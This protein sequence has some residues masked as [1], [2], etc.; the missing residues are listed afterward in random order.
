VGKQELHARAARLSAHLHGT[1]G[2]DRGLVRELT[3]DPEA[4]GR[5]DPT[6]HV[7]VRRVVDRERDPIGP[8]F[9][10]RQLHVR[11]VA[12]QQV[13]D[14]HVADLRVELQEPDAVVQDRRKAAVSGRTVTA[15]FTSIMSTGNCSAAS[16]QAASSV[17]V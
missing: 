10:Q 8:Q 7:P 5:A 16:R 3:R 2:R 11:I 12:D 4:G 1:A 13:A 9:V 17:R 6:C 15:F 14:E